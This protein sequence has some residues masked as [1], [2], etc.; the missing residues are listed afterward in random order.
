[1]SPH[2]FQHIGQRENCNLRTAMPPG[3]QFV[4]AESRAACCWR[5]PRPPYPE[6][7]AKN[8]E[9]HEPAGPDAKHV[10]THV[11]CC[12]GCDSER[13]DVV[14]RTYVLEHG[15]EPWV[16]GLPLHQIHWLFMQRVACS[17]RAR[18]H[19]RCSQQS[20]GLECGFVSGR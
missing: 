1:M 18:V 7:G 14:I 5:Q 10:F 12:H 16:R 2:S 15:A 19:L 4:E 3:S 17:F 9:R 20:K 11:L 13:K 6:S 8:D